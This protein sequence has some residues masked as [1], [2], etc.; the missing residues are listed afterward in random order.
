MTDLECRSSSRSTAADATD[1]RSFAALGITICAAVVLCPALGAFAAD[2]PRGKPVPR[3]QAIPQPYDQV[4]F[5]RDGQEIARYHFGRD[6]RRPFVFPIVGPSGRPLTRMGH[7]RDPESHSHHNSVWVSHHIVNGV[8][9][10]GDRGSG[11]GK[12][13]HQ[14]IEKLEDEPHPGDVAAVTAVNHW[15]NEQDN[16]V[17]FVERR[18]KEVR[19]LEAGEWLLVL[20][21]H[22]EAKDGPV[23]LGKT[24]FGLVGV[25]M[26]KTIGVHDGGGTVRNS[27]GGVNEK[28]V[29]WKK[30]RWVDY[31]GPVAGNVSEGVTLMD[32]PS[33]PN[34]PSVFHVRDDGWM[35]ASLTFDGER[36]VR[37]GQPLGLRYGLYVHAG[38]PPPEKLE[39]QWKSFAADP[40]PPAA[41]AP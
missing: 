10:W 31:S 17:L 27:E 30:A 2:E 18:R 28:G 3:L 40:M 13:V 9:F 35:G 24:P 32:H 22:L 12:I 11:K 8:D 38:V 34:H 39:A 19:L 23:T 16:R 1:E 36:V 33:N 37:P 26:A 7:P 5:Q 6:L 15:V 29:F 21:L 14:R 4:S 25:R 20:D 41:K